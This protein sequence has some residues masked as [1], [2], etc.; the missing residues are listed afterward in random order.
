MKEQPRF[1]KTPEQGWASMKPILD[2]AMPEI[3][4]AQRF[5]FL[6]WMASAVVVTGLLGVLVINGTIWNGSGIDSEE[7]ITES[8]LI[9]NEHALK[10][11]EKTT[12][13]I[14]DDHNE[15]LELNSPSSRDNAKIDITEP[16][17]QQENNTTES[18]NIP[19]LKEEHV[20]PKR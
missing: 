4:P 2:E 13:N 3:K 17:A 11:Y 16:S 1:N 7:A 12:S 9:A 6:W 14:E 19:I 20:K 15:N 8:A 18:R 5:P 10:D